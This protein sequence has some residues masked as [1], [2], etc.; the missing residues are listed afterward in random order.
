MVYKQPLRYVF[1]YSN[2]L[3]FA[4]V[5]A[6]TFVRYPIFDVLDRHH[7]PDGF[8]FP[9]SSEENGRFPSMSRLHPG[10]ISKLS[11]MI[12]DDP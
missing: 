4:I 5:A 11:Q 1:L 6:R 2:L 8:L 9:E 12:S 3:F 10:V 7:R